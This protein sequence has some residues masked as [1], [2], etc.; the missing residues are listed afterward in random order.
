MKKTRQTLLLLLFLLSGLP[1]RAEQVHY[2]ISI[3]NPSYAPRFNA[4][5]GVYTFQQFD[6]NVTASQYT[7]TGFAPA[8]PTSRFEFLKQVYSVYVNDPAFLTTLHQSYPSIFVNPMPAPGQGQV[9]FTPN[10]YGLYYGGTQEDLD[11]I[12][13]QNAWNVTHGDS[14]IKIGV[15]DEYVNTSHPD[16]TGKIRT[17]YSNTFANTAHGTVVAGLIAGGTNNHT[18]LASIGFDSKINISNE[19]T[20]SAMLAMSNAGMQI[21]NG[22]WIYK[23]DGP[24]YEHCEDSG[25]YDVSNGDFAL[26]QAIYDEVY[27]NGTF[28][29]FS[30]GNGEIASGLNGNACGS[31]GYYFPASF[32]H[33]FSV[34]AVGQLENVNNIVNN[35][36]VRD[37]HYL[38]PLATG[39]NR[40]STV[41]NNRVDLCAP[42]YRSKT[43]T[44]DQNN[45]STFYDNSASGTSLSAPLV[46]GTAALMLAAYKAAHN[47]N[48]CLSP[49]QLEYLLKKT[50]D[51]VDQISYN[52]PFAGRLG[53]GRL[54]ANNA[55]N[56]FGTSTNF[57]VSKFDCNDPATQTMYIASVDINSL[58]S[59]GMY[60]QNPLH[61]QLS[62]TIANGTPPYRYN[63]IEIPG[64]VMHIDYT[65]AASPHIDQ[66]Q[67]GTNSSHL[68]YYYLQVT[69]ASA[70]PKVASKAVKF[71]MKTSGYDLAMKDSPYDLYQEPNNQEAVDPRDWEIWHS[72]DLWVHNSSN[73][74]I[75]TNE[76]A[77][78][79]TGGT[80]NNVYVH[81]RN[82]GCAASP[83]TGMNLHAYWT[84]ASTGEAWKSAWDTATAPGVTG[85]RIAAGGEI[86]GSIT[87]IALK[88]IQPGKDTTIV[89]PWTVMNP[90]A[91]Y[92][93]PSSVDAC[94][95]A[96]IQESNTAPY[97]MAFAEV[98]NTTTNVKKNNNI[99]TR[100]TSLVNLGRSHAKIYHE[101]I[102]SN[103]E[104]ADNGNQIFS[105]QMLTDKDIQKHFAG[106]LSDYIY[107]T[108]TLDPVLFDR[109]VAAGAAGSYGLINPETKS[110]TYDPSTPLRL[111]GIS[112]AP[113]ERFT[114]GIMFQLRDNTVPFNIDDKHIY[115]RQLTTDSLGDHVY[116]NV[117]YDI[118][119]DTDNP[120]N[121]L[122][123]TL[124]RTASV[125]PAQ[126]FAVYPNPANDVVNLYYSGAENVTIDIEVTDITGR[127]IYNAKAVSFENGRTLGINI[128]SNTPGVYIVHLKNG[129]GLNES[130][131]LTKL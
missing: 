92:G 34:T 44:Y 9:C 116:G 47:G 81:I 65:S 123:P 83:A 23:S 51:P 6:L 37:V 19:R 72:P 94:L 60:G 105:L 14:S 40:V 108:L 58:C 22:S 54:N 95:L 112:L 20:D 2:Y 100:N 38:N 26:G 73:G 118:H 122:K 64:N 67:G 111:D 86:T 30:A 18:G 127:H 84:K 17:V 70:I 33:N 27:E 56:A 24:G 91:Y 80:P 42:G 4:V 10:D 125:A 13:A 41:H 117:S 46:T 99:V 93:Q 28:A 76:N 25:A 129:K 90:A 7:I 36:S 82:V 69:D 104:I 12:Q 130:Y 29:V 114:V 109:W 31:K 43:Y 120:D 119:I 124:W 102:F 87:G 89:I 61:P 11:L 106:N 77:E 128:A 88:S 126:N 49:Y 32:D 74:P 131:R 55:V 8:F 103:A 110:V 97:G 5:T 16:L 39:S 57:P 15:L 35:L 75:T 113:G 50:S 98:S 68:F 21:I 78:F 52:V 107:A 85:A 66:D 96:R 3:T 1:L 45:P 53:A 79:F 48:Q 101:I 71:Q 115:V 59:P 63:W 62:V 121:G